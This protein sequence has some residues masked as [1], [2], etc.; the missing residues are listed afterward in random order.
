MAGSPK[1]HL[2]KRVSF[3]DEEFGITGARSVLWKLELLKVLVF[4]SART[5]AVFAR[6]A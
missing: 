6:L 3:F 1:L 2:P 4:D 5:R